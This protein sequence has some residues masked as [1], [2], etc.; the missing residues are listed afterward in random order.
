MDK[1]EKVFE[2]PPKYNQTIECL[3]YLFIAIFS[4]YG[5]YFFAL[6]NFSELLICKNTLYEVW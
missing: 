3:I 6:F 2:Y 5:L 1:F 4:P